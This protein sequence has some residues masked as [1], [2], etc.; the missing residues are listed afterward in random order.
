MQRRAGL[1]DGNGNPIFTLHALRHTAASHLKNMGFDEAVIAAVLGH[2]NVE[3]TRRH[4]IDIADR[5][6]LRA[7]STALASLT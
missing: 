5:S 2:K 6:K 1:I 7:A 4:Y 3:T